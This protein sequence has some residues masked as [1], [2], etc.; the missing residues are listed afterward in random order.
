MKIAVIGTGTAGVLSIA[1]TLS[2]FD[3]EQK[4]VQRILGEYNDWFNLEPV[5][6]YSIYDPNKAILGIGESTSTH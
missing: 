4:R 6:V 2:Y 1:F 3:P 5:E